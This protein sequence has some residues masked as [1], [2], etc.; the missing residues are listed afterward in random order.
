MDT[1]VD[2]GWAPTMPARTA[3]LAAEAAVVVRAEKAGPNG[4]ASAVR[5]GAADAAAVMVSGDRAVG[6][7]PICRRPTTPSPGSRDGYRRAGS[8]PS[9]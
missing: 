8:P 2:A 1:R 6:R 9:T 7:T 3:V 5:D 4:A